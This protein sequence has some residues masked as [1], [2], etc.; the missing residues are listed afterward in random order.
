MD[1]KLTT[2][3]LLYSE[4]TDTYRFQCTGSGALGSEIVHALAR[5][6]GVHPL[7][8]EPL[9]NIVDSDVVDNLFSDEWRPEETIS[10]EYLGFHVTA[11]RTG[12]VTVRRVPM[13]GN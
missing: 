4:R 10:F 12:D 6:S 2:I 8:M 9:E 11:S 1:R 3:D 5:L 7:E 13:L